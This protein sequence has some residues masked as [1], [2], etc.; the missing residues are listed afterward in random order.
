MKKLILLLFAIILSNCEIKP[1]ESTAQSTVK[2]VTST[3]NYTYPVGSGRFIIDGVEY[4]A[5]SMG[6]GYTSPFI[7]NL[8]K[9]KLEIE[10]LKKQLAK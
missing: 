3:T 4:I 9:D 2:A 7:V 5:F 8:T 6:G 1:R 10:L